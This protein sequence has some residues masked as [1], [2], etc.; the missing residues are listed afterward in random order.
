MAVKAYKKN[1][2]F[3][4]D[5]DNNIK[6]KPILSPSAENEHKLTKME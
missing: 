3:N 6:L 2:R 1:Y 4:G 5:Y